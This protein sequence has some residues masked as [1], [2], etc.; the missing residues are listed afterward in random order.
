M[1]ELVIVAVEGA[2]RRD[3]VR[4]ARGLGR[5]R[6]SLGDRFGALGEFFKLENAHRPV[7]YNRLGLGNLP[8]KQLA[9]IRPYIEALPA[10]GN[11]TVFNNFRISVGGKAVG[12]NLVGR[13]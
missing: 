10:L 7:P 4:L 8:G 9:G 11:F 1:I 3:V 13:E 6:H 5:G 12:D 2:N